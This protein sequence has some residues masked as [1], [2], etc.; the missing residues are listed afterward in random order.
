L[1]YETPESDI[2]SRKPRNPKKDRLVT[3]RLA[4]FSYGWLSL[5]QATAGVLSYFLTFNDYGIPPSGVSG[6]GVDY[7]REGASDYYGYV[8]SLCTV[9]ANWILE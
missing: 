7:F 3:A 5:W 6:S 4:I 2:M 9:L 1:A 8:S